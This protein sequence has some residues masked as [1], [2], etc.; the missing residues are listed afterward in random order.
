MR[1]VFCTG[2]NV[3]ASLETPR[4]DGDLPECGDLFHECPRN[5]PQLAGAAS[6]K[7]LRCRK[8]ETRT[9]QSKVTVHAAECPH[10]DN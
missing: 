2:P 8:N 4:E 5:D 3:Q 1:I 10:T 7:G 6:A 9:L